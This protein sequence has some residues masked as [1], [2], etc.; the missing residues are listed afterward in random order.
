MKISV[1]IPVYNEEKYIVSCIDALVNNT[2]KPYEIIVVDGGST[3]RTRLL[4][5]QYS[6]VIILDNRRKTAAAGRSIGIKRAEVDVI[7]FTD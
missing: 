6:D 2:H 3:D 4:A 5:S 1:V 7:A